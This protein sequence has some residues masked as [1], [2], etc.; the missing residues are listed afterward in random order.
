MRAIEAGLNWLIENQRSDGSWMPSYF[1]NFGLG[2]GF[3]NAQM[4]VVWALHGLGQAI[5]ALDRG[6]LEAA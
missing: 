6:K 4:P 5:E 2:S 3:A 1:V